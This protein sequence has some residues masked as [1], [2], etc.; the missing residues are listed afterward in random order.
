M[1][2]LVHR[3]WKFFKPELFAVAPEARSEDYQHPIPRLKKDKEKRGYVHHGKTENQFMYQIT[4][5]SVGNTS[6]VR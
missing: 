3:W 4:R 1:E 5:F 6:D 2:Y